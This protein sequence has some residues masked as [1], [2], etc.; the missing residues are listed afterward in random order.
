MDTQQVLELLR[1]ELRAVREADD[2][3]KAWQ[4]EMAAETRATQARTATIREK[5]G[6][7]HMEMVSAF[8][9][10]IEEETMACREMMDARLEEEQPASLDMKPEAAEREVPIEMPVGEPK[11]KRRR[12]QNQ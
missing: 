3:F 4:E 10:E 5:M 12:D 7:S 9:P 2:R 1:K 6:T 11:K 8:K